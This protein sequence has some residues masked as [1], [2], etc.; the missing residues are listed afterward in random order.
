MV[1]DLV[2]QSQTFRYLNRGLLGFR[3]RLPDRWLEGQTVVVRLMAFGLVP[4]Y[5]HRMHVISVDRS[6]GELYAHEG[7]GFVRVWNHRV[8]V[9]PLG[10]STCRYSDEVEL[11]AGAFTPIAW[12]GAQVLY[13]Y[14]QLRLWLLCRRQPLNNHN[15]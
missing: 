14:R 15:A 12:A 8:R 5:R 3:G 10:P 9:Q 13:G 4:L 6:S 2:S 7:G 1:W 11:H